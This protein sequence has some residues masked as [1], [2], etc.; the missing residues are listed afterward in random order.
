VAWQSFL[1]ESSQTVNLAM[2]P[3]IDSS[4]R[5]DMRHAIR[6][7]MRRYREREPARHSF[8]RSLSVIG[9]LGW[10]IAVMMVSGAWLGRWLDRQ[11]DTGVRL[12]LIL[13]FVGAILGGSVAW[14][15]I[16]GTRK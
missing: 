5:K 9:S 8:W 16:E 2:E 10:S 11:W 15:M 12:T 13:V 6:R 3:P 1:E 14:S 4:R 7:D